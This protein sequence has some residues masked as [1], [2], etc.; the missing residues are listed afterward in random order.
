MV[1]AAKRKHCLKKT[2]NCKYQLF[3]IHEKAS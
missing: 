2:N 3:D 1:V